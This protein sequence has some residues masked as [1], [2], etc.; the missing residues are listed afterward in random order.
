MISGTEQYYY[1]IIINI[2]LLSFFLLIFV[3]FFCCFCF[4][5]N[6]IQLFMEYFPL[7]LE[8]L[9][10][11]HREKLK[12]FLEPQQVLFLAL[13]VAKGKQTSNSSAIAIFTLILCTGLHYLH[14]LQP[15]IMHR[16]ALSLTHSHKHTHC[17]HKLQ[18]RYS[19]FFN[20]CCTTHEEK[21]TH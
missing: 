12:K 10:K 13:E 19:F 7:N 18:N 8:T 14:S 2:L 1:D 16:F 15:P 4:R 5:K 9:I 20:N 21:A 3:I 17:A 6:E 11:H